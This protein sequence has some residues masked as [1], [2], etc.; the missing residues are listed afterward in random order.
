MADAHIHFQSAR[1]VSDKP[2]SHPHIGK[3]TLRPI[4]AAHTMRWD[5]D[6]VRAVGVGCVL[7]TVAVLQCMHTPRERFA[8][9]LVVSMETQRG[10]RGPGF[11]PHKSRIGGGVR[12]ECNNR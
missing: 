12:Y 10:E 5:S 3:Q 1:S 4:T 11:L 7:Q 2:A 6:R 8:R 9:V